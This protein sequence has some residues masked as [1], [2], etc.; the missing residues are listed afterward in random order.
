MDG[1]IDLIL[2]CYLVVST[3]AM[4]FPISPKGDVQMM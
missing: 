3:L 2:V 4:E 1:F